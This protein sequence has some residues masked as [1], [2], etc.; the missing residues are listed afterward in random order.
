[1]INSNRQLTAAAEKLG[2]I[3]LFLFAAAGLENFSLA[4]TG[5]LMMAVA[6]CI[7][8]K[9]GTGSSSPSRP[10]LWA[11]AFFAYILLRTV[12]AY[13]AAP[14]KLSS[15]VEWAGYYIAV[16]GFPALA[17]ALWL[18]GNRKL[19]GG[20]LLTTLAV[21]LLIILSYSSPERIM[22]YLDGERALFGGLRNATGLYMA[23]AILGIGIF[24]MSH[25]HSKHNGSR[26]YYA[27]F[28]AITAIVLL[29][30]S[31]AMIWHQNRTALFISLTVVPVVILLYERAS[32]SRRNNTSRPKLFLLVMALFIVIA[33]SIASTSTIHDRIKDGF[34]N[35]LKAFDTDIA[36][37]PKSPLSLRLRLWQTGLGSV[38]ENPV[39][40]S[41][42]G[43]VNDLVQRD[44]WIAQYS[45]LHNL[46]LQLL[47]ELGIVGFLLFCLTFMAL[48][49]SA[50]IAYRSHQMQ[51]DLFYF[52]LGSLLL[53][54]LTNLTQVRIDGDHAVFYVTLL[55]A[56]PMT[57]AVSR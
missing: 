19:I 27:V 44:E 42:P 8:F 56:L 53:F 13:L 2:L 35:T 4:L 47:V 37:L 1:M 29:I 39:F 34:Q 3:G 26:R 48:F 6:A 51:P 50:A 18:N 54:L 30:L 57:H 38:K 15:I 32:T 16:S 41:G 22:D 52:I 46:Y 11:A 5:Y 40:G 10:E 23:T 49:R 7:F 45:H 43:S 25:L 9:R 21:L 12:L 28:L 17:V 31:M 24:T 14:D 36:D 33:T 20:V 55:L